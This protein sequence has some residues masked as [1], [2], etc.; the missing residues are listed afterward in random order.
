MCRKKSAGVDG[1]PIDSL[2]TIIA[3][4]TVH[5]AQTK[6]SYYC[7]NPNIVVSQLPSHDK[8]LFHLYIYNIL[9]NMYIMDNSN[10][11][12]TN[13]NFINNSY[14]L[15]LKGVSKKQNSFKL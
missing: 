5:A 7:T 4:M 15:L 9:N 1:G 11:I 2:S 3:S 6:D 14:F 10:D 8:S 13:N 12:F